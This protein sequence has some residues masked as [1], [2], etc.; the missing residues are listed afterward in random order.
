M[1]NEWQPIST[2]PPNKTV[3]VGGWCLHPGHRYW[4]QVMARWYILPFPSGDVKEWSYRKRDCDS[5][6]YDEDGE[7]CEPTWWHEI[8]EP[9]PEPL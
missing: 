9:P 6:F 1:S 8:P 4:Q 3:I 2:L 7:Y 5:P